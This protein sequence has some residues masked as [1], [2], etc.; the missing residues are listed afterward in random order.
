VAPK[1]TPEEDFKIIQED[2]LK[3]DN[4]KLQMMS[5][6]CLTKVLNPGKF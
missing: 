3:G 4:K 2:V 6:R 1:E 5:K